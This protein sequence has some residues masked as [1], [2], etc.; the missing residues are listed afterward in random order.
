M[1]EENKCPLCGQNNPDVL[2][3]HL[4]ALSGDYDYYG[5]PV[6]LHLCVNCHRA[7][8]RCCWALISQD[9]EA[10]LAKYLSFL[11]RLLPFSLFEA[12]RE[13]L[14]A[15]KV[16]VVRQYDRAGAHDVAPMSHTSKCTLCGCDNPDLIEE[17]SLSAWARHSESI[18]E[19]IIYVCANCHRVLV[20]F[21][22]KK[23]LPTSEQSRTVLQKYLSQFGELLSVQGRNDVANFLA[24]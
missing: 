18:S 24:L 11:E 1:S 20:K 14:L 5:S 3:D 23:A 9:S 2:E 16:S 21:Y 19:V 7:I 15:A 13:E 17:H 6:I 8:H 22:E 4:A 10:V 12:L